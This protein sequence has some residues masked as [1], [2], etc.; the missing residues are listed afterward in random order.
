MLALTPGGNLIAIK[1]ST[2]KAMAAVADP[3]LIGQ[4]EKAGVQG[5]SVE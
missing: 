1:F 3:S 5:K 4:V 2:E